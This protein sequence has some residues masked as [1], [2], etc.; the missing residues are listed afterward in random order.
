MITWENE[1]KF[2]VLVI[3]IIVL[4]VLPSKETAGNWQENLNL[5]VAV[6]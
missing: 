1:L 6:L 5:E 2:P 3:G 4:E